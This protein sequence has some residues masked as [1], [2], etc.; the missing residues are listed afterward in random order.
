MLA[1]L[2]SLR[3]DGAADVIV[4]IERAHYVA[5]CVSWGLVPFLPGD[6]Y[7]AD[8]CATLQPSEPTLGPCAPAASESS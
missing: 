5:W 3:L 2:R 7:E 6:D 1:R 8:P 4:A